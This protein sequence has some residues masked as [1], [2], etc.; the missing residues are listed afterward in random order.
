MELTRE[1]IAIIVSAG[2]IVVAAGFY[3]VLYRPLGIKLKKSSLEYKKVEAELIQ[4]R[5]SLASLKDIDVKRDFVTE[6]GASL[7][8]DELT[9]E[10]KGEKVNFISIT[11]SRISEEGSFYK[12]SPIKMEIGASYQNLALFL[13]KLDD[14]KKSLVRVK[15]LRVIPD[16]ASP[17]QLKADMVVNMYFKNER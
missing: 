17:K 5:R 16:P 3:F 6:R 4:A 12:V 14:L 8:L 13:G 10:G 9:K 11:P 7:A 15:E 1:R 2:A